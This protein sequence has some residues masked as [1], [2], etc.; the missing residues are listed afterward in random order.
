MPS[1][2]TTQMNSIR[3]YMGY[4]TT[5]ANVSTGNNRDFAYAWVTPGVMMTL[6][7]A[8]QNVTSDQYNDLTTFYLP[9][10]TQLEQDIWGAT[11]ARQNLD[12]TQ[13]AVWTH[14]AN[15]VA[16]RVD[17]FYRLCRRLANYLGFPPGPVLNRSGMQISRA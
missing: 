4:P 7:T 8:L 3:W 14:N 6:D 15:E 12:T 1:L 11:G 10:L 5:L 16:D 2:T 13:A 17:L 9:Q